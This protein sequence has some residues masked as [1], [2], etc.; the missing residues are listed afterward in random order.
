M[1]IVAR[2]SSFARDADPHYTIMGCCLYQKCYFLHIYK[3]RFTF[4]KVAFTFSHSKG[5]VHI[6]LYIYKCHSTL[7]YKSL[8]LRMLLH[9]YKMSLHICKCHPTFINVTEIYKLMW[10]CERTI[11]KPHDFLVCHRWSCDF[12]AWPMHKSLTCLVMWWG[13]SVKAGFWILDWNLGWRE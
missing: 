13:D 1:R 10:R 8:H 2:A 12:T 11:L 4:I 3:C 6:S 5:G 7:I 9:I